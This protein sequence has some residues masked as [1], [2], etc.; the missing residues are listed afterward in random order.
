MKKKMVIDADGLN[1]LSSDPETMKLLPKNTILTPHPKEV[2]RLA[3]SADNDYH[4]LQKAIDFAKKHHIILILKGAFTAV[5]SPR[6]KAYFNPTGNPGMAT[7]GSGDTLTG[8][9][10]GLLA[11]GID[12]FD[13]ARAAVYIHGLA[14]DMAAKKGI[15]GLIASDIIDHLQAAFKEA[16]E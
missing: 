3:G 5:I 2:E 12:S 14:G 15:R 8:I 16:T 1:I 6:G 10:L 7:A 11:S 4:R 9:I 13:A